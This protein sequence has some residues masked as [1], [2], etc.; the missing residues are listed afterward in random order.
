M[1]KWKDVTSLWMDQKLDFDTLQAIFKSG[2]SR[3][4]CLLDDKYRGIQVVGLLFVKDLILLDPEDEMPVLNFLDT[5]KHDLQ[6]VL[7]TTPLD[8]MLECFRKGRSH[9][10]VVREVVS[11]GDR[12]SVYENIGIVTLED[13]IEKIM[14]LEIEDEYDP[15]HPGADDIKR[16]ERQRKILQLFDYRRTRG[17]DNMPPQ[18]Q[19]VVYRHLAREVKCFM[20]EHRMCSERSLRN[21]LAAG[22]VVRVVVNERVELQDKEA[23][24]RMIEEGGRQLYQAN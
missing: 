10:A 9:L 1:T 16:Q 11:R 22:K 4:P 3:I 20:P 24:T 12:D 8:K 7:A 14:D 21:L 6:H 23:A 15:N 2:H 19:E 5:F 13:I 17:M 18:E